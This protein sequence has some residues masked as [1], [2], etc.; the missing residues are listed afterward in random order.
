MVSV[1]EVVGGKYEIVRLVGEGGM[2]RVYLA[3]DAK[4]NKQ[5]AVKEIRTTGTAEQQ[6]LVR[7]SL[8]TE[9]NTIK[10]LDHPAFPRIV[11]LIDENGS[12]YVVMDYIE[13]VSLARVLE[14]QG[15]QSQEDVIDWGR[16]LCDALDYL[17]TR[18]P[19]I[20][21]RDMK[22]ANVM[23]KPDG[24]VCVID[25]GIAREYRE[26]RAADAEGRPQKADDTTMLG[27]KGYAAP[28]QFG[29]LGQTDARTDVYCLGATLY[30][31]LTGMSPADPPYVM[32]PVRQVDP[33]LSPGLEKIVAK[34][35]QQN[36]A[37]RYSSCAEM[38]YELEHYDTADDAHFRKLKR[39][40]RA[41]VGVCAAA[42]LSLVTGVFGVA[43]AELS[44]AADYGL[45]VEQAGKEADQAQAARRYL[46]AVEVKPG[47]AEAYLGLV[48]L[49]KADGTFSTDEEAQLLQAAVPHLPVVQADQD[50]YAGLAFEIGRLYWYYYDYAA[51]AGDNRLTRVKS[52]GRWMAD[53]AAQETFDRRD[54]A[55]V[56]SGIAGF[57]DSIV[58]RINEGDDAGLYE[59]YFRNLQTLV[60]LAGE[61]G[62][63]VVALETAS[64]ASDALQTY[65]RKFRAD[66]VSREDMEAL[67]DK[68]L[69]NAEAVHPTTEKLDAQQA[70]VLGTE[71]GVR[72]ALENA[73]TDARLQQ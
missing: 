5:W 33:S 61:G 16:Q 2:S 30:H 38:L 70:D 48:D 6:E 14:E 66:G 9:A 18:T 20:V 28:E 27:T 49:Y 26:E 57:N 54:L 35:T 25:F 52:A 8:V 63:D 69:A 43:A 19:P 46:E 60:G 65:A 22:P 32:Y 71:E 12:L 67:L 62:N 56:Y 17:H 13:G 53:A 41:F 23:L 72:T 29:G 68:A 39:T 21:Y 50:A 31:L 42:A 15:P 4:L 11:D 45:L 1:G 40:W 44:R 37:S 58:A 47:A 34:A 55:Q 10:R 36:P 73:F 7:A 3:M 24:T 64:L 51:D 59:P